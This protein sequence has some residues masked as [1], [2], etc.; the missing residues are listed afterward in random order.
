MGNRP[1]HDRRT[2]CACCFL[3]KAMNVKD[4]RSGEPARAI[5]ERA[6]L[7]IPGAWLVF[8]I[9]LGI[10]LSF[11]VYT[12]HAWEDFYITYRSSKNLAT[13]NGLV[14]TPGER[15][16]A[17][18]SPLN[19][20]IPAGL[21]YAM[22]NQSD[23]LVLWLYRIITAVAQ[24]GAA[25]LLYRIAKAQSLK[26]LAIFV[27]V[28][29]FATNVKIVDFSINGQE[30]G[31]MLFFLA[32]ALHSLLAPVRAAGVRL[33]LAWAGLMWTRPDG[34]VY[35]GAIAAAFLLF[36]VG[37]PGNG[38]RMKLLKTFCSAGL[39][40]VALYLPWVIWAWSYYGSPIPNTMIAKGLDVPMS[41]LG[42]AQ[43][44]INF[45]FDSI[46]IGQCPVRS[47]APIYFGHGGWQAPVLFFSGV[48]GWLAL[49]YWVL[50][51]GKRE[52]RALSF[53]F[54]L[55]NWYLFAVA[56]CAAEW[57]LPNVAILAVCVVAQIA[58]H[59]LDVL[60]LLRKE[61]KNDRTF[62]QARW[63]YRGLVVALPTFTALLLLASAWQLRIQQREIED[64]HREQIGL[65][66]HENAK[67]PKDTV[68]LE[69]LGYIGYFSQLKM[70]DYP[71]LCSPEVVAA[72]RNHP[73]ASYSDLIAEL[74]PDWLVLR[75]SE[76]QK[77]SQ[78][79]RG[80][81]FGAYEVAKVFDVS[82]QLDAYRLIPGRG[83]L[84][85]DQTFTV[86]RKSEK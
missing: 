86:F 37:L 26:T 53:A 80:E 36:N 34:W 55:G 62:R 54:L 19:V 72:R 44:T 77:I 45:L 60:D 42:L 47:F 81:R 68:F 7:K 40:A 31:F 74:D 85:A 56:P 23:D 30:A 14:F 79:E 71:G 64:L 57:Y 5:G 1:R 38:S 35:A 6:R 24:A 50:P 25:V 73:G 41:P 39:L 16:H 48:P 61:L 78:S 49:W 59:G 3:R 22:G 69:P 67:S 52:T 15:V 51:F 9:V 76:A 13:G 18:T 82:K 66:L 33:G 75:P 43:R 46:C 63:L 84:Q 65:W 27:L 28:G 17:F 2:V 70:L 10:S 83:Y 4:D 12:H 11:A 58:Q 32:L 20:L 8:G 29:L 21:S